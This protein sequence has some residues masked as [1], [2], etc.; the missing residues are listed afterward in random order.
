MEIHS[1]VIGCVGLSPLSK[2]LQLRDAC[3]VGLLDTKESLETLLTG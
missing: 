2:K 3:D 1:C